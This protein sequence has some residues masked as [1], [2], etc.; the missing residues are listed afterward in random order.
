[1]PV[2]SLIVVPVLAI[3]LGACSNRQPEATDTTS[4]DNLYRSS[5][6]TPNLKP[7]QIS[8]H[9]LTDEQISAIVAQAAGLKADKNQQLRCRMNDQ[10]N[11]RTLKILGGANPTVIFVT[12]GNQ[13]V[14]QP[15]SMFAPHKKFMLN[16]LITQFYGNDHEQGI[17]NDLAKR[18]QTSYITN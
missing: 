16:Q 9:D 1:M 3:M 2:R 6:K 5:I 15:N 12:H 4:K 14:M 18:I 17:T 7:K 10:T 8:Y 11:E 13:V